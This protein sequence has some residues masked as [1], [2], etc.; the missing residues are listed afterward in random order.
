MSVALHAPIPPQKILSKESLKLLVI[1]RH[2]I[3]IPHI[4]Q[5]LPFTENKHHQLCLSSATK[6]PKNFLFLI[7]IHSM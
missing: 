6:F 3:K 5:M 7:G 2:T 1:D 4:C